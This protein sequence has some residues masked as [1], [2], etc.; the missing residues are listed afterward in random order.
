MY[1]LPA[2]FR[3]LFFP[4]AHLACF[5]V[6]WP[7]QLDPAADWFM[8]QMHYTEE[9][10]KRNLLICSSFGNVVSINLLNALINGR[11]L[12]WKR[13]VWHLQSEQPN[14]LIILA[15]GSACISLF[16]PHSSFS[17]VVKV[18]TLIIFA[19]LRK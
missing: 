17:V 15:F 2:I 3:I 19:Y 16:N 13:C 9:S 14:P 1:Q 18:K 8:S 10:R 4:R 6:R 5:E 12:K 7:S 11:F